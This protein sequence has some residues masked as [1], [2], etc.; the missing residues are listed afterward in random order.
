MK[1][2]QFPNIFNKTSVNTVEDY[3]ATLQNL[4]MLILSEKQEMLG[5]PY[6][7][8]RL[9]YF[10][11]DQNDLILRDIL[12]DDLYTAITTFMPQIKITRKDIA[13][14]NDRDNIIINIEAMN[15]KSFEQEMYS[16]VLTNTA[17]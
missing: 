1:S 3:D 13:I 8:T 16:I 6:F 2:I 15:K 7:G 9:Q 4:K 17:V 14:I 12:I 10:M 11:F 5:D